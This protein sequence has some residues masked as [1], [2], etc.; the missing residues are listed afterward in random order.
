MRNKKFKDELVEIQMLGT[1][2]ISKFRIN[3]VSAEVED[4]GEYCDH[5]KEHAESYCCG[6]MSFK[7]HTSALE[8]MKASEKYNL[9]AIELERVIGVLT[10]FLQIGKCGMC[11]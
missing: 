7:G 1:C 6:N 11:Q 5:D 10:D 9:S 3:G 8:L 4:F 2:S